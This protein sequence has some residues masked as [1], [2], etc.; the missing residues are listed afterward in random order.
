[1]QLQVY[2]SW[3]LVC[4]SVHAVS[5]IFITGTGHV[6][7]VAGIFIMRIGLLQCR[8]SCRYISVAGIY[9]ACRFVCSSIV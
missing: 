9:V 3:G 4:Y 6:D 2:L 8:C 1:M 7:A 5:G